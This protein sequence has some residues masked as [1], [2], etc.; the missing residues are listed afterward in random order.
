MR[1]RVNFLNLYALLASNVAMRK[2][3]KS[4]AADTLDDFVDVQRIH[5]VSLFVGGPKVMVL[6]IPA[7]PEHNFVTKRYRDANALHVYAN[8]MQAF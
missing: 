6:S 3:Y 7:T 2:H 5:G 4:S 1:N 8:A